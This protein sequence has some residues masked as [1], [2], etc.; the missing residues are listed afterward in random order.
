MRVLRVRYE[1]KVFYAQLGDNEVLCLNQDL[2]LTQPIPL[3]RLAVLPP[4][5]PSK[6]VCAGMNYKDHA[7]ELGM[8]VPV[9]PVFFYKPPTAVIGSGQAIVL[10]PLRPGEDRVDYEA[11]LAMVVGKTARRVSVEDAPAHV[12]GYCPA[13]DVTARD[14]QKKDGLYGRAK[15]FDTFLP[16]GPW[17]E[18]EVP[19]LSNLEVS[20]QVNGQTVQRGNTADMLFDPLYLLSFMSHVMTLLPGDVILTGAP[21][22]VGP[23]RAGDEVRIE[24]QGVGLCISPVLDT[25]A[26]GVTTVR[27]SPG[28]DG[29][30]SLQ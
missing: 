18:T 22:G 7:E 17:I 5:S 16:I 13:N 14:L 21:A 28:E 19:D 27:E 30:R 3:N 2:G 1:G 11:E 26:E 8:P 4:V 12:F 24:V 10:P 25:V 15:G 23:I 20:A 29:E 9:E 6:V